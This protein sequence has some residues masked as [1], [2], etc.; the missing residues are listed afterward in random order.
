MKPARRPTSEIALNRWSA[1]FAL[2]ESAAARDAAYKPLADA[3]RSSKG[4][5]VADAEFSAKVKEDLAQARRIC[6]HI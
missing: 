4:R 3:L 2:S 6:S 5:Y 1:A